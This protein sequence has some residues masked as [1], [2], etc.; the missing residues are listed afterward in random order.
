VTSLSPQ[1]R[2]A[3]K[4]IRAAAV[5]A[6][7][8]LA[9]AAPTLAAETG[10]ASLTVAFNGMKSHAGAVMFSLSG[11]SAAYDGK[12][13]VAGQ[14]GMAVTGDQTSITF[15]GLKPGSY[16]IRAFHDLNGDGKLNTNPF[17]IPT[18]PY[19]FS[20]NARGAMGPP[21]WDAAAFEVKAGENR[22]TID[23][24]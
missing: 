19:A 2:Q 10:T 24:D 23:I 1:P 14:V 18:E 17:G 7:I 20:N 3:G 13:P 9:A 4:S 8:L 11:S 12:A 22:Q 15:H 6:L 16:A 5:A 21:G